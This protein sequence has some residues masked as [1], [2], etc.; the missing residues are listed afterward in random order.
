V[1]SRRA[2]FGSP[3]AE[4]VPV[5]VVKKDK[6][7]K[8]KREKVKAD[9][10]HVAA[11]RELRDRYLEQFNAGRVLPAGKYEVARQIEGPRTIHSQAKQLTQAA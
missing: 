6:S 7:A 1:K 10:K 5:P 3:D 4:P 9:P 8:P 2:Q 11:A